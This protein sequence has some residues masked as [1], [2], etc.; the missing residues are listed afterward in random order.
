[1]HTWDRPT[2]CMYQRDGSAITGP[3]YTA[4]ASPVFHR[5]GCARW[6]ETPS[7]GGSG[8]I[9]VLWPCNSCRT[10]SIRRGAAGGGERAAQFRVLHAAAARPCG[11]AVRPEMTLSWPGNCMSNG[12]SGNFYADKSVPAT[13]SL[14]SDK[15]LVSEPPS[16]IWGTIPQGRS[17]E[18]EE[19]S[20]S[21]PPTAYLWKV[22]SVCR[23]TLL[24]SRR[25][26]S[27]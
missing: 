8:H 5:A 4:W 25:Y 7:L 13:P 22:H 17:T 19:C 18:Q 14:S 16:Q 10:G 21:R 26:I 20:A 15:L 12:R 11:R 9:P 6:R 24:P 2:N 23:C 3:W 1:M 27:A